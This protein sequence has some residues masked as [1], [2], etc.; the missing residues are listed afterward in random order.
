MLGSI[1]IYVA[2]R[3]SKINRVNLIRFL[4]VAK[5]KIIGFDVSVNESLIVYLLYSLDELMEDHT[6]CFD[7]ELSIAE[8]KKIFY[9]WPEIF[10][11]HKVYFF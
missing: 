9:T 1:R 10:G 6:D 3:K 11:Y 5:E 2:Y 4:S 7:A 8:L